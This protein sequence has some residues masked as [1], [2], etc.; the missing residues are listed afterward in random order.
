MSSVK[1][2][3]YSAESCKNSSSYRAIY[4]SMLREHLCKEAL[5]LGS[6]RLQSPMRGRPHLAADAG[7]CTW[8]QPILA[9]DT[10]ATTTRHP[11]SRR[12]ISPSYNHHV[13][14]ARK[15]QVRIRGAT[16][17]EDDED[18]AA[19]TDNATAAVAAAATDVAI[20]DRLERPPHASG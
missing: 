7:Q 14:N 8:W 3:N 13:R 6:C 5:P 15:A 1:Q 17:D 11:P 2:C 19:G 9:A 12:N 20:S 4:E 10:Y 18:E 16:M